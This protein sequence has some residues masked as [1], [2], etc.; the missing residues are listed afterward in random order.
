MQRDAC[1]LARESLGHRATDASRRAGN[2]NDLV[3]ELEIHVQPVVL[4]LTFSGNALASG[5]TRCTMI[6]IACSKL[7]L[8][9]SPL[10]VAHQRRVQSFAARG[11]FGV[12][13]GLA[14][15]NPAG[16]RTIE[17]ARRRVGRHAS[18]LRNWR[19]TLTPWS[20]LDRVRTPPLGR[21]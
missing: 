19:Q 14:A 6:S 18:I 8:S 4:R 1:S 5:F 21:A 12:D 7:A 20:V 13:R 11:A 2:Q 15:Q 17:R 9:S 16:V 3:L 10:R